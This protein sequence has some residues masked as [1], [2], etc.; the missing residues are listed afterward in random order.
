MLE[1]ARSQSRSVNRY[2]RLCQTPSSAENTAAQ[3]RPLPEGAGGQRE[4]VGDLERHARTLPLEM[5]ARAD[6]DDGH[7]EDPDHGVGQDEVR[8]A[9][10]QSLLT[11]APLL[12]DPVAVADQR[13]GAADG[14]DHAHD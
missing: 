3:E 4:L 9:R 12:A 14:A 2:G 13:N 6:D 1:P 10:A 8:A 5:H 11:A 7:P